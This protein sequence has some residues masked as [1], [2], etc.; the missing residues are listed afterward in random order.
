LKFLALI[1]DKNVVVAQ[2]NEKSAKRARKNWFTN[3][4]RAR[5]QNAAINV[6][7]ANEAF[8]DQYVEVIGM[9]QSGDTVQLHT[10][11][12]FGN[13]FGVCDYFVL[14]LLIYYTCVCTMYITLVVVYYYYYYN[15]CFV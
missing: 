8:T 6:T 5:P 13:N 7:G 15:Y 11:G 3:L 2:R 4:F 1:C 9:A 14:L 12:S 10:W